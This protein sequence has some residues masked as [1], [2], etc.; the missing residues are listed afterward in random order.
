MTEG[1]TPSAARAHVQKARLS[2]IWVIPLVAIALV[3]YLGYRTLTE[4]GPVITLYFETAEGLKP[5]TTQIKYKDVEVGIVTNIDVRHEAPQIVVVCQLNKRA[6]VH[7]VEGSEFWV[8]RP[9]IGP[10][11][12][13]GLG[14]L[15]SGAYIDFLPGS[16][17]AKPKREFV[18]LEMPP[19]MRP[20]DP[21]LRVL[22]HAPELGSLDPGSPVYFRQRRVGQVGRNKLS[23][24]KRSVEIAILI[25][26][27]HAEL[28]RT[29]SRFWNVGGIDVSLG[30][31]EADVRTE[32]LASLLAGGVAFD[33]PGGGEPAAKDAKFALHKSR[34]EVEDAAWRYGGLYVVVEAAQLGG[35]KEGDFV[36]YREERVGSVVLTALSNDARA[37]RVHL[38]IL[39]RYAP[40]VR[41]NS[42]F[43]NASGLSANLGLAGLHVHTESLQALLSGGIAFATPDTPGER[44]KSGSVFKLHPKVKDDWLKWSP[45]LGRA[46]AEER[47]AVGKAKPD[48]R[49]VGIFFHHENK[50]EDETRDEVHP[51]DHEKHGF[52]HRLLH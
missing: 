2:P 33:S 24:D 38:N 8:V 51:K 41:T 35:V 21:R 32:P 19:E 29:N 30:L 43:W 46:E 37:V 14:T 36:F 6:G 28:V 40:L 18:G 7:A 12:I 34:T 27:E 22:L 11:G 5:D 10:G 23:D 25:E 20:D 26:P 48:R 47:A 31:G 3:G 39:S 1:D 50:S 13:S 42:V 49:D 52:F 16:P 4:K 45:A 9:R 44:V 17:D 15:L